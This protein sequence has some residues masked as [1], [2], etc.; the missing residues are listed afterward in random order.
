MRGRRCRPPRPRNAPKIR[1]LIA[2]A[3]TLLLALPATAN[4]ALEA[5]V[6]ENL[7]QIEKPSRRTV[8]PLVVQIA[9]T[10]PEGLALLAAWSTC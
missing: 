9:A 3:L 10:G 8:E 4:P 1:P 7:D 5:V 6:A 2:L